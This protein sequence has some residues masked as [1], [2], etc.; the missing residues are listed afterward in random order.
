MM[1]ASPS[2]CEMAGLL[3]Y[4]AAGPIGASTQDNWPAQSRLALKAGLI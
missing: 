1:A 2:K 4:A 3:N